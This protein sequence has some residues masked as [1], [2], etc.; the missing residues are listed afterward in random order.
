MII[1]YKQE[2]PVQLGMFFHS[3]F[4]SQIIEP[5]SSEAEYPSLHDRENSVPVGFDVVGEKVAECS[6]LNGPVQVLAEIV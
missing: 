4:P 2:L 5:V 6:M 1:W 3:L